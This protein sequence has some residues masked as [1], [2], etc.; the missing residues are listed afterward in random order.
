MGSEFVPRM[1]M[2]REEFLLINRYSMNPVPAAIARWRYDKY[3]TSPEMMFGGV[4]TREGRWL[5]VIGGRRHNQVTEIDW[6]MNLTGL[7]RLSLSTVMR[8]YLLEHEVRLGTRRLM[9]SGGT[10]HSMRHSFVPVD[11]VDAIAL[12][13]SSVGRLLRTLAPWVSPRNNFLRQALCDPQV[14]WAEG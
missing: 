4:R 10:P 5:S 12:R 14:N 6:Q 2:S 3:S 1:E 13:R 7:P 8:S 11:V 9:F